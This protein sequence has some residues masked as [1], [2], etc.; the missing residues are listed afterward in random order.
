MTTGRRESFGP[1]KLLSDPPRDG[2]IRTSP[3]SEGSKDK[4]ALPGTRGV[5]LY[6]GAKWR[7]FSCVTTHIW[8]RGD[9]FE[10]SKNSSFFQ[11]ESQFLCPQYLGV[12]AGQQLFVDTNLNPHIRVTLL[13]I[14]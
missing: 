10:T 1:C 13:Q 14:D 7:L 9:L 6:F 3:G 11:L 2:I 5:L 12:C 4:G 8:L